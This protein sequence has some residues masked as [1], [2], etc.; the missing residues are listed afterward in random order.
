M[1]TLSLDENFTD[2]IAADAKWQRK[3]KASPN[4]GFTR[5][6]GGTIPRRTAA[7]KVTQLE[8]M[9]G[10]IANYC[11]V[12]SR[13][14]IVKNSTS[15]NAIWQSIRLHY[16]FQ[17][18]GF[19]FL[20]L[21]EIKLEARERP[22]DLNQR[23][24][25]FIDDNLLTVGGL[26][27]HGHRLTEDE[28][29][30]PTLENITVLMW[31]RLVHPELP[32]L[33]KQRYST[34]LH[35]RTL[36]TIKPEILQA[37][38]SLL[39]ELQT[40]EEAKVMRSAAGTFRQRSLNFSSSKPRPTKSCPSCKQAG[41]HDHDT[42]FLSAC[43]FLPATDR[44]YL[45]QARQI[46]GSEDS[47]YEDLNLDIPE[48]TDVQ[49]THAIA[50]VTTDAPTQRRVQ[51]KQ[52]PYL[53][54]FYKQYPIHVTIDSGAETNL[55]KSSV[56]QRVGAKITPST[57]TAL[58]ADGSTPLNVRGETTLTVHRDNID[59]SLHALVVD[60]IDMD[61]LAGVPFM[62]TNDVA[63]RPARHQVIIGDTKVCRY[64]SPTT[65]SAG[66]STVRRAQ[67]HVI[68]APD[69]T[70]TLWP[71]DYMEVTVPVSM[72]E[73][74]VVEPQYDSPLIQQ[75]V[76]MWPE[77]DILRCV[78]DKI[79]IPNQSSE[80]LI[81]KKHIHIGH[82]VAISPPDPTSVPVIND[83]VPAPVC[84]PP[85][86][87]DPP[88]PSH[89]SIEIDRDIVPGP[90]IRE[91]RALHE[92]HADVF[93]PSS[94]P[95][96]NNAVGPCE[97]VVNMGPVQPLQRKG[98][99]PQ[100]SRQKL[101]ELQ[102]KFD[103]LQSLGVF[104]RPEEAGITV[105]Y[106]NPS[107]LINKPSGGYRLVTSFA[108]VGRYSKP[109]PSILP[110]VDSTLRTIASW[111][112]LVKTD[113]TKAFYQIPLNKKSMKYCGVSTPFKGTLVYTRSAMGMPGLETAL[114]ELMCHI[115]G[116]HLQNG[117]I[118]K[119]AD[120]LYIG[121]NT[122]EELIINWRRVLTT[123][124]A[125]NIRLSPSKTVIAPKSTV[126][127]GWVWSQG[128]LKASPNRIATLA[129]CEPPQ[130]IRGLRTFFG[131]YKVLGRVIPACAIHLAPLESAVAGKASQDT[132]PW[133]DTL[134]TAFTNA[135]QVL[136]SNSNIQLPTP[137]DHLWIVTDASVKERGIGA[138]LYVSRQGKT[139]VAGFFSSKLKRHQVTWLPCEVEARGIAA[140]VKHFSPYIVQS[141][142]QTV[143]LTDSKPCCQGYLKLCRGEFSNS[144]R[145]ST[146]L[147]TVSRYQVLVQHLSGSANTPADFAS[148]NAPPCDEPRCQVCSFVSQMES[149]VVHNVT[150]NDIASGK[151]PLPFTSHSAWKATQ[152]ECPDLRRVHAHLAQGTRPSRKV[153]N[154]RDVKRY[155]QHVII[156]RDGLLVIRHSDPFAPH[157]SA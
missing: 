22:E 88:T 27:H 97:A 30:T 50:H 149:A 121:G 14:S 141:H 53:D 26:S 66:T 77:P 120:D 95:G 51:V 107:F 58:Q 59:L 143:V 110:D 74:L 92:E 153:T 113:L 29:I 135:Q 154:A 93:D 145:V 56:A 73:F 54:T 101:H 41:R 96:Y 111:Q 79:R 38:S 119:I 150:I 18:S 2:F 138:T 130:T 9:L 47:C 60:D 10:Q 117:I 49:D 90:M 124:A 55:L 122:L 144:P 21:A 67:V 25:A 134:R 42:H 148:R 48:H 151:V 40:A 76:N 16:G 39:D 71:G 106:I 57:Q 136:S 104:S 125:C 11:P 64:E 52:S 126:I 128:T 44:Q 68:R 139:K 123:L 85:P 43:R 152:A 17:S 131:A 81:I 35:S 13:N 100:Y 98:R 65:Q 147:S 82:V 63:V 61:V 24:V 94:I 116:D 4:R 15:L 46:I 84:T 91:F 102:N 37:L 23:L 83:E 157:V 132:L 33:V 70:T 108:D 3:T 137:D 114:K 31:L 105:E 72:S 8:L 129:S 140:A 69:T 36:S 20:D 19:H 146:Y 80:P 5:D 78:G 99:V 87:N 103:K 62:A 6:P 156:A 86:K 127:L 112:Y 12:I 34:E 75:G 7:Q 133:S 28:E 1:Y 115:L 89:I 142:H 155:L 45:S 32:R 109:Q 118:A